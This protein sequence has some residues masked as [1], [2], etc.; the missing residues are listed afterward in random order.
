[1]LALRVYYLYTLN[2]YIITVLVV[3][4]HPNIHLIA[5]K[6]ATLYNLKEKPNIDSIYIYIVD[7]QVIK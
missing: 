5:Y 3:Y 1:M 7:R 6:V 2:V 4:K